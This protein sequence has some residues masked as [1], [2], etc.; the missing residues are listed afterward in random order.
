MAGR[1]QVH[2][3]TGALLGAQ[4]PKGSTSGAVPRYFFAAQ[5]RVASPL[6]T[7]GRYGQSGQQTMGALPDSHPLPA[8]AIETLGCNRCL[9]VSPGHRPSVP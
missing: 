9:G 1:I 2:G 7:K 4:P 5:D 6:P 3:W 8:H